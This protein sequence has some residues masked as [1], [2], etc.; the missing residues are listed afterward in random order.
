MTLFRFDTLDPVCQS[1]LSPGLTTAS[2]GWSNVSP[3]MTSNDSGGSATDMLQGTRLMDLAQEA[4]TD[5]AMI[6][7]MS[8]NLFDQDMGEM[9]CMS[10]IPASMDILQVWINSTIAIFMN[11]Y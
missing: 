7:S 3:S 10:S 2:I 9:D 8:D 11:K 5:H 6:G 1:Y 4:T